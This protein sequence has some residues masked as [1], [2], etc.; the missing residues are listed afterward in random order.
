MIATDQS[1]RLVARKVLDKGAHRVGSVVSDAAVRHADPCY[2]IV[3]SERASAARA[4]R[5]EA[6]SQPTFVHHR[7]AS[8][9]RLIIAGA[10]ERATLTA[11]TRYGARCHS[12]GFDIAFLIACAWHQSIKFN[13]PALPRSP[14]NDRQS[15]PIAGRQRSVGFRATSCRHTRHL[16]DVL[17]PTHRLVRQIGRKSQIGGPSS[18]NRAAR[19]TLGKS[20]RLRAIVH[21]GDGERHEPAAVQQRGR[22]CVRVRACWC[23]LHQSGSSLQ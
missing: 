16:S 3:L 5:G 18:P 12:A 22:S 2:S 9:G 23:T 11:E 4:H 14:H 19:A 13:T 20:C 10:V 6:G 8:T 17:A 21:L 15:A 1:I 7:W